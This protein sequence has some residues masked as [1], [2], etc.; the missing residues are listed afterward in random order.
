M[1][2]T[3]GS[4]LGH[5]EI[6]EPIGK[7]GMG[8][9]YRARDGKLGRDVAIKVLP[10]ELAQDTERLRRFQREAKVL[11]S[12]NHPNIAAIYG[13]EQSESMHY[14]VLEL[15]PGET[16]AERIARGP[17]PVEEALDIATKIADALEEA[18]ERGIV[19]RDLKPANIMLTPDGKVKVLDFGLA[20]AFIEETPDA[21]SSMSPTLTRD[22]TRV[23]V[24][25]GTAAYMSPEQAKGKSVD[26]RA[27]IFAFGAVLYE[28]LSARQAFSGESV[29]DVLASV[30]KSEP[31][32][33]V[34]PAS[35][36]PLLG[37]L[38]VRCLDK[39]PKKRWRDIGDVRVEI[40]R[41]T[42]MPA[43]LSPAVP[44]R[45]RRLVWAAG[46][47]GLLSG[48]AVTALFVP[49]P[50][51]V[52]VTRFA[53]PVT[54]GLTRRGHVVAISPDGRNV[55]Y[56]ANAEL[57]LRAMDQVGSEALPGTR[58]GSNPA[59]S[60]DGRWIAF[61]SDGSLKKVQASGGIPVTLC[62]VQ[63][64]PALSWEMDDAIYFGGARA[65]LR[66]AASGGE[67]EVI[68]AVK[69]GE[70]ASFPRLLPDGNTLL[71]T[72]RRTG[73]SNPLIMSHDLDGGRQRL[74][75]DGGSDARYLATG[76]LVYRV[77][78]A[79][80][81]V[82]FDVESLEVAATG[83]IAVVD[84]V[85]PTFSAGDDTG[86]A[87]FSVSDNGSLVYI[88][89]ALVDVGLLWVN[90]QGESEPVPASAGNYQGAR[91]SPDGARLA[92][93]LNRDIWL[94][95]ISRSALS[96]LTFTAD[97]SRAVWRPDG[98]R[99]VFASTRSGVDQLFW[100]AADGSGEAERLTTGELPRHPDAISP[101]GS[102]VVF[103]EH[104][105][106]NRTD[107]WVLEL[108]G[109]REARPFLR[110]EFHERLAAVSPNGRWLA[111]TSDESGREEV[112]ARP[113]PNGG[114]KVLISTDGGGGPVWSKGGRELFYR[115]SNRLMAVEVSSG[116]ELTPG[117]VTLLFEKSFPISN[118]VPNRF[119]ATP[120]GERFLVLESRG[121]GAAEIQVVL[122]WF[123]ELERLVPTE[124]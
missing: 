121:G 119:D 37:E 83:A 110:T 61:S 60:P 92:I 30:I 70:R 108:D 2:L 86:G 41:A 24:I 64:P 22:A 94:Y 103:H 34:L 7:G 73:E 69:E 5:Y 85:S 68:I 107:L 50:A 66:V 27:D 45:G 67:P 95:D 71:F 9:V 65:I 3:A 4:H 23:G 98:Q 105:P 109:S 89:G 47:L 36:S 40:E 76:H 102:L 75:V 29:S 58:G 43:L 113:F 49:A 114:A 120:G 55:A 123:E 100:K 57:H 101:D 52:A 104:D 6:L 35:V 63:N 26:K 48:I 25:L 51:E 78:D 80:H 53:I 33:T 115:N 17:I 97:N 12:L 38:L 116:D 13:L 20:K 15:V 117:V 88:Q 82:P 11:A 21:D 111:Y 1:P 90:R 59:F 8:E 54:G 96:R 14:L 91:I 16:L 19:H 18:H 84:D 81:V 72:L 93:V 112:Y 62:A 10:D 79:L 74:L 46:V 28:M 39:D 31:D 118:F 32:W 124:N 99:V 106:Q 77:G 122:N 87:Q 44:R 42:S 56:S